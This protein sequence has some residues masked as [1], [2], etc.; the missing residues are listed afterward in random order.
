MLDLMQ[1]YN[2]LDQSIVITA[3]ELAKLNRTSVEI[4]GQ[5]YLSELTMF[6]QLHCL[7][8]STLPRRSDF[9]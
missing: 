2:T 3:N 7:V 1:G 6:H 4:P 8:G 5:G 9:I